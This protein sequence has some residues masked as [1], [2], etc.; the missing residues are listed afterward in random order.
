MGDQG[1]EFG[2]FCHH[3]AQFAM[4]QPLPQVVAPICQQAL[5]LLWRAP[6][7]PAHALEFTERFRDIA[8]VP[9]DGEPVIERI[10]PAFIHFRVTRAVAFRGEMRRRIAPFFRS[11]IDVVLDRVEAGRTRDVMIA[12]KIVGDVERAADHFVLVGLPG[13]GRAP[14]CRPDKVVQPLPVMRD[15]GVRVFLRAVRDRIRVLGT[16][17]R[18][19]LCRVP[20]RMVV[21][22]GRGIEVR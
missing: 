6:E 7:D 15:G 17:R 4:F 16:R 19:Q 8:L 1:V 18:R 2:G 5:H 12:R 9:A 10:E 11:G 14:S 20:L 13:G 22:V 21:H 3:L